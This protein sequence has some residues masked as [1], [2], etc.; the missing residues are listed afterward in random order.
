MKLG[1]ICAVALLNTLVL[2]IVTVCNK[3]QFHSIQIYSLNPTCS[4]GAVKLSP[5]LVLNPPQYRGRGWGDV[6]LFEATTELSFP[7]REKSMSVSREGSLCVY[8]LK[9]MLVFLILFFS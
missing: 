8:P 5:G 6:S 1:H 9:N 7:V 4:T 3:N 2:N